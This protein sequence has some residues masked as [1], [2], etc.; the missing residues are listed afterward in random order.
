MSKNNILEGMEKVITTK[1]RSPRNCISICKS[2][3]CTIMDGLVNQLDMNSYG[4]LDLFL[5]PNDKEKHIAIVFH[6]DKYKGELRLRQRVRLP[7]P[8]GC[9]F[10]AIRL[11][12]NKPEYRGV[13]FVSKIEKN[14]DGSI[15]VLF[16]PEEKGFD[17]SEKK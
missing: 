11:V 16:L 14:K 1:G 4:S 7:K 9:G 13:Y 15:T 5:R 6:K 17:F 8:V 12:R 10:C 2:G 3:W